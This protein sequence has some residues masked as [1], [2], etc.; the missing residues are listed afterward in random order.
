[1][2]VHFSTSLLPLELLTKSSTS[3]SNS[4]ILSQATSLAWAL[5]HSFNSCLGWMFCPD[6]SFGTASTISCLYAS[7]VISLGG[8]AHRIFHLRLLLTVKCSPMFLC[9]HETRLPPLPRVPAAPCSYK[10]IIS[11][12]DLSATLGMLAPR[13]PI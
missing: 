6:G 9:L 11:T 12:L 5:K 13:F 4:H 8:K 2:G 7:D 1:M 3:L 10:N